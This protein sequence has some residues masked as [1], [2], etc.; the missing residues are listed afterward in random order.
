MLL[1]RSIT[2]FH[3]AMDSVSTP[4]IATVAAGTFGVIRIP[5]S[6][7]SACIFT[8][9]FVLVEQRRISIWPFE[10]TATRVLSC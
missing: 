4:F 5:F 3:A 7:C 9:V 6:C 8:V 2:R 1:E 10:A